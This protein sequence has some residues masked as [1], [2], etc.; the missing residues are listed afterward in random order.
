MLHT[1]SDG[2]LLVSILEFGVEFGCTIDYY[3]NFNLR[4][5]LPAASRLIVS[6]RGLFIHTIC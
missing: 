1:N 3:F 4:S 2:A 6:L 5:D